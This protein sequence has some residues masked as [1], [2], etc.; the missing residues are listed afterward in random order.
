MSS[1]SEPEHLSNHHRN[2]LRQLFQHPVSH[3]IEWDAVMSLLAAV[4]SAE[5]QHDGRVAVTVGPQTQYFDHHGGKDIDMQTV[6]DVRR[7]LSEAG[8]GP[9]GHQD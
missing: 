8:Y 5:P 7:M 1:A 2:T 4:G 3:N 6:I 9:G